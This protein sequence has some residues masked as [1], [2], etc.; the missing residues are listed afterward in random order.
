[1]EAFGVTSSAFAFGGGGCGTD[2]TE[3]FG[4]TLRGLALPRHFGAS[5]LACVDGVLRGDFG[6]GGSAADEGAGSPELEALAFGGGPSADDALLYTLAF[7]T[8]G[9]FCGGSFPNAVAGCGGGAGG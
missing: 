1:M 4:A 9:I 2:A 3:P 8:G 5:V 6:F 7:F